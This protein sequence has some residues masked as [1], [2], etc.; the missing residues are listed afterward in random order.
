MVSPLANGKRVE[1][2]EGGCGTSARII[3]LPPPRDSPTELER[4]RV[5]WGDGP[6]EREKVIKAY[7]I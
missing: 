5:G 2:E 3:L 1:L 4:D 7:N 6:R